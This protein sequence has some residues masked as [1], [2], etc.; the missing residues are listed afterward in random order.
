MARPAS[1]R[2]RSR[3]RTSSSIPR[4]R[5]AAPR[6]YV[7]DA[8]GFTA[9]DSALPGAR[10]GGRRAIPVIVADPTAAA[11][12]CMCERA[13]GG[14]G[15]A[16]GRSTSTVLDG[17]AMSRLDRG[18]AEPRARADRP[19][20]AHAGSRR[21]RAASPRISRDGGSVL[22]SLGPDVD[23][24]A[25]RRASATPSGVAPDPQALGNAGATLVLAD[26]RHPIFRPFAEPGAALGDVHVRAATARSTRAAGGAG[27][28]LRRRCRRCSSSRA[29][30]AGCC[31]SRRI[32]TISGTAFR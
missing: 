8:G 30:R 31:S 3:R 1:T 28:I 23:P 4:C 10:P 2:R 9:D 18:T 20:H 6:R 5:S 16:A 32:S 29:Q 26:T 19:R 12:A 14:R 7:E 11:A 21:P 24:G 17:R 13:L 27:A 15:A 25:R 22:L